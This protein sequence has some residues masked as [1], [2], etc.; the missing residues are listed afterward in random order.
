MSIELSYQPAVRLSYSVRVK[1]EIDSSKNPLLNRARVADT[2]VMQF[3]KSDNKSTESSA[4]RKL[5]TTLTWVTDVTVLIGA[6]AYFNVP[7]NINSL[8]K[9]APFSML[10]RP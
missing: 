5:N 4:L 8:P 9:A 6:M 7:E 2:L 3:T 1:G 10:R